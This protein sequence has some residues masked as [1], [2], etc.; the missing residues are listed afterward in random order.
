M[1]TLIET[2]AFVHTLRERGDVGVRE[3]VDRVFASGDPAWCEM[4][5][6]ELWA[7]ARGAKEHAQL[8]EFDRLLPRLPID[9]AVW[10]L[11]C[12]VARIARANGLNLPSS[13]VLIFACGRRHRAEIVQADQHFER[14]ASL[15][16]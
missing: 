5:R 10:Q 4:I 6:L 12:D 9:A 2:S 3:Q 15:P 1:P 7:G 11:A 13:D 16:L 8:A 14:L